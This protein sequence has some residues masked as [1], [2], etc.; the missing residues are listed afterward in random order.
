MQEE[1]VR[2]TIVWGVPI[3]YSTYATIFA[4]TNDSATISAITNDSV[5]LF[6]I[7]SCDE[8]LC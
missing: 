8:A 3:Q 4:I 5:P 6:S 1:K 2:Y 7:V